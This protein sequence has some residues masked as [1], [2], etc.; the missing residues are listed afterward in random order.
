MLPPR[1]PGTFAANLESEVA[2]FVAGG[3]A[4]HASIIDAERTRSD[5]RRNGARWI[6]V[7][8]RIRIVKKFFLGKKEL[9]CDEF[10]S[11]YF[12]NQRTT[13]KNS[14]NSDILVAVRRFW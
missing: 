2:V 5:S 3:G 13:L 12:A 6:I 4:P 10:R 7:C 14:A 8:L 9:Q 1:V 11:F